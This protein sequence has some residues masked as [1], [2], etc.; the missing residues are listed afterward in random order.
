MNLKDLNYFVQLVKDRNYT[1]TAQVF[2]VS[3]PTITYA[4]KRLEAELNTQ[5]FVRDQSHRQLL[6]TLS[7]QSF[8]DHATKILAEF[9]TAQGDLAALSSETIRFGL[10]PIIGTYYFPKLAGKL[11]SL[12]LM[13]HIHTVE[14]GSVTLQKQL[15]DQKL[16]AA[17]LGFIHLKPIEGIQTVTLSQAKFQI[18]TSPEHRWSNRQMIA[19]SELQDEPFVALQEGFIHSKALK[20]LKNRDDVAPQTVFSTPDIEVLK[21]M[22][23]ENV[24]VGF[25]TEL[26]TANDPSIHTIDIEGTNDLKFSIVLAYRNQANP[27]VQKLVDVLQQPV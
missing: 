10:P 27:L 20:Q 13:D 2:G 5:L 9:E 17:L 18:I 26:A 4:I 16:D 21:S 12:G 25:L 24:G 11:V 1:K 14:A 6:I 22:V 3:Q 23:R 8:N 15:L 19:F 7:G